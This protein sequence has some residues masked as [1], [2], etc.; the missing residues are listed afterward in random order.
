MHVHIK[1]PMPVLGTDLQEAACHGPARAMNQH[2]HG[3][4][5]VHGLAHTMGGLGGVAHVGCDEQGPAPV[6]FHGC[7]GLLSLVIS[8][9]A[10]KGHVGAALGQQPGRGRANP[11]GAARYQR[12]FPR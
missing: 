12:H 11:P 8:V 4:Q 5:G 6:L 3:P 9:P 7:L 2:V 1:C 10:D